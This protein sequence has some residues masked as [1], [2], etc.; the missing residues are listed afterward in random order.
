ML[1]DEAIDRLGAVERKTEAE[2]AVELAQRRA[3][4]DEEAAVGLRV[5]T[6]G[7]QRRARRELADDLFEDVLEREQP[8]RSPYCLPRAR[9]GPGAP[10]SSCIC[11]RAGSPED[12]IRLAEHDSSVA[13]S[14]ARRLAAV[15]TRFST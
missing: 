3:A 15:S 8:L 13:L 1:E 9:C 7:A 5:I 12:E 2:L 6:A 14:S 10:E 11:A 4:F